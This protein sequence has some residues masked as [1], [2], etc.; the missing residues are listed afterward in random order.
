MRY[1]LSLLALVAGLATA[2]QQVATITGQ[3]RDELGQPLPGA[4]VVLDGTRTGTAC[5]AQ[6]RFSLEVPAGDSIIVRISFTGMEAQEHRLML[7]PGTIHRLEARL[8]FTTLNVVDIHTDR[9][10]REQGLVRI[11]PRLTKFSPTP[12]GGVE[13]LLAGQLGVTFRSELG[14]GYNV[15]GG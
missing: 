8:K 15:R 2:A 13:A 7:R 5:D 12:R 6:G 4:N 10:D 14:S 3:V 11:D 9:A 1:A